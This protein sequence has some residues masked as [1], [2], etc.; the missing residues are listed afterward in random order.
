MNHYEVK[1]VDNDSDPWISVSAGNADEA[2]AKA[3]EHWVVHPASDTGDG[4]DAEVIHVYVRSYPKPVEMKPVP[5]PKVERFAVEVY[6]EPTF[7]AK[8]V[9]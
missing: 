7:H 9:K 5:P 4:G 8:K 3:V 1:R 6:W 2:A